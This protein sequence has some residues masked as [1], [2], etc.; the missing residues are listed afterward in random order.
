MYGEELA[1]FV[2]VDDMVVAAEV[3]EAVLFR[4]EEKSLLSSG[5]EYKLAP[6]FRRRV[7]FLS[8]DDDP[9]LNFWFAIAQFF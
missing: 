6:N 1:L 2:G 4:G 5:S 8:G 9:Q 7:L 3:A